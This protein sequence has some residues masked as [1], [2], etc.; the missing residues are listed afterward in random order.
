MLLLVLPT[1]GAAATYPGRCILNHIISGECTTK[2]RKEYSMNKDEITKS[3]QERPDLLEY[4]KL[5]LS[6]EPEELAAVQEQLS[7]QEGAKL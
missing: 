1:L 4:M 7:K 5:L 6:L 3:L 2:A